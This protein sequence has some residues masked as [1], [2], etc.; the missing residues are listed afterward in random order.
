MKSIILKS[1]QQ[2]AANMKIAMLS[3]FFYRY[4]IQIAL[5]LYNRI[6]LSRHELHM[7]SKWSLIQFH[8]AFFFTTSITAYKWC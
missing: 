6:F 2:T 5:F 7:D 4:S 8:D 1:I 3:D